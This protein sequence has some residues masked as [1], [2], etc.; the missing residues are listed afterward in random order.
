MTGKNR[1]RR[2]VAPQYPRIQAPAPY[3]AFA[4]PQ[5]V[6]PV[7][8]ISLNVLGAKNATVAKAVLS[9]YR[10]DG[11]SGSMDYQYEAAESSKREQG[12]VY[13]QE[14]GEMLALARVL[15]RISRDLFSEAGKRVKESTE[16]QE[17]L[18]KAAE[19]KKASPPRS[20]K[21]RTREEWER[22]QAER[23]QGQGGMF[24]YSEVVKELTDPPQEKGGPHGHIGKVPWTPWQVP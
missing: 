7:P 3:Q 8:V 11:I 21:G 9:K 22:I 20:V 5:Y 1:R 12:D 4:P 19:L 6:D 14:T 18:R 15:Q 13:D 17:A 24:D 16:K 2:P 10:W 23:Y